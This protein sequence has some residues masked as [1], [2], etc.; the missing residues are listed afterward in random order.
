[1]RGIHT[2]KSL[3]V[4]ICIASITLIVAVG[5]R[6]ILGQS[7]DPVFVLASVDA[8]NPGRYHYTLTNQG[9]KGIAG[10]RIGED[11]NTG[12]CRLGSAPVGWQVESTG[13]LSSI[14]TPS[15]WSGA[16]YADEEAPSDSWCLEFRATTFA[17][18]PP[19]QTLAGFSVT[20]AN[21]NVDYQ[22]GS[23][24]VLF[25]DQTSSWEILH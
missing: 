25:E 8:L 9:Q 20:L 2:L 17:I 1:M 24:K 7:S 18:L 12:I 3:A 4:P 19:T 13:Q 15:G 5:C 11:P 22:S 6:S 23:V 16:A 21:A 10:L 14:V